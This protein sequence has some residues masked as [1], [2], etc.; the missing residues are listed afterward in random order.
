[1]GLSKSDVI[2]ALLVLNDI[3]AGGD[4]EHI[5]DL[6]RQLLVGNGWVLGES[7]Q[8]NLIA[9]KAGVA[10]SGFDSPLLQ[11]PVV[12]QARPSATTDNVVAMP[13]AS[14]HQR[15]QRSRRQEEEEQST[16]S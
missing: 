13:P 3:A 12:A 11:R 5:D 9:T 16:P 7:R 10:L 2:F 4:T 14:Q 1:M 15:Q 8:H 6:L